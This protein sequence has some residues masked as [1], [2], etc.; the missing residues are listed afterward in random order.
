[1]IAS[2]SSFA[3]VTGGL[4]VTVSLVA[5]L[6]ATSLFWRHDD[7]E[8]HAG[9]L[10]RDA[11]A[12]TATGTIFT[13]DHPLA[14]P[15]ASEPHPDK[16]EAKAGEQDFGATLKGLLSMPAEIPG[17]TQAQLRDPHDWLQR[18]GELWTVDSTVQQIPRHPESTAREAHLDVV[19]LGHARGTETATSFPVLPAKLTL[20]LDL[21]DHR[22]HENVLV[23]WTDL[24][25]GHVVGLEWVR[26]DGRAGNQTFTTRPAPPTEATGYRIDLFDAGEALE[27][28]ASTSIAIGP[29]AGTAHRNEHH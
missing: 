8:P 17:H 6:V 11:S 7:G 14:A 10:A 24:D 21:P 25:R 22:Y 27:P 12:P 20:H 23:R 26:L 9:N 2:A 16:V 13:R 28:I 1:M 4:V 5:T 15:L 29:N 18:I 19:P 3:R